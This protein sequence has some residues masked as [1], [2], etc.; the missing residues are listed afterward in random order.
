MFDGLGVLNEALC[1][2]IDP[3][4]PNAGVGIKR[5]SVRAKHLADVVL[6]QPMDQDHVSSSEFLPAGHPLPDELAVVNDELDVEVLHAAAGP[7]LAAVG[8][9]DGTQPPA[10]GEIR[11]LDRI[12][13]ARPVDL[14]VA[15]VNEGRVAFELGKPERGPERPDKSVSMKS[16]MMSWA[17]S[18]STPDTK[19]V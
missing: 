8:L 16:A 19:V 5:V 12:L 13:Q 7:A 14:V 9:L 15:R 6:E 2:G 4:G 18:S 1:P 11:L 17:R 3:H 10:E